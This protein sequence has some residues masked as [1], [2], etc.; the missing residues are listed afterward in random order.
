MSDI[1]QS[2]GFPEREKNN[3][4]R[5]LM[6]DLF[7]KEVNRNFSASEEEL[8]KQIAERLSAGEPW[9]YI[10]GKAHFYGRDFFVNRHVLIP[11]METEE[12]VYQALSVFPGKDKIRVLDIGAGSGI[13]S[14]T[15]ALSRPY[16]DVTGIDISQEALMVAEANMRLFNVTNARFI[17]CDFLD[18]KNRQLLGDYDLI[19]SN[20]PYIDRNEMPVMSSSTVSY[21]PHIALFTNSN[22]MEFYQ[23]MV[24]F[25]LLRGLKSVVIA[26]INEFRGNEVKDV[27]L[28]GG[29]ETVEIIK[30]LQGKDR[31]V[32]AGF[33]PG[34]I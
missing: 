18:D 27:F 17:K 29:F 10:S 30:D 23:K 12:L 19:I 34:H 26:E 28:K 9:Q 31:M 1:L 7:G 8:L 15:F 20:P 2:L 25:V 33:M 4:V 24:D 21:E 11:R 22:P 5:Y 16:A 13:I 32:K 3:I 14:L 6:D